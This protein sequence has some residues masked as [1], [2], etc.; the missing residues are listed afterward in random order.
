[1]SGYRGKKSLKFLNC[2]GILVQLMIV[3]QDLSINLRAKRRVGSKTHSDAHIVK[4]IRGSAIG[5]SHL[6]VQS[7]SM[8]PTLEFGRQSYYRRPYRERFQAGGHAAKG[9]YVEHNVGHCNE[10]DKINTS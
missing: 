9:R 10:I 7:T 8:L 5:Y 4:R 3:D 2:A 6:P 1:M